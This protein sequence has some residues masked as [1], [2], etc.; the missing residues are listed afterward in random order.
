MIEA[1]ITKSPS[2]AYWCVT[3]N[4]IEILRRNTKHEC[5]TWN[6]KQPTLT[7]IG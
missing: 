3:V 4:N 1:T 2:G 5:V 7:F 6:N